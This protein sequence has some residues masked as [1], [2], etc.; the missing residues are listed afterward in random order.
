MN[1]WRTGETY[2]EVGVDVLDYDVL[3]PDL[4][5]KGAREGGE[6]GFSARVGG[7]HGGR[8]GA[9]ERANVE[10]KAAFSVRL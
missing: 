4:L 1:A 7:K 8:D 6:E 10:D 9:S 2:N 3:R 5:G